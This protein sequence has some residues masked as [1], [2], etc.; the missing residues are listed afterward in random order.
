MNSSRLRALS[1]I[2]AASFFSASFDSTAQ[3]SRAAESS[4]VVVKAGSAGDDAYL[5]NWSKGLA[6]AEIRNWA[7]GAGVRLNRQRGPVENDCA[8][9]V[10]RYGSRVRFQG[11]DRNRIYRV[12][13]D[14]VGFSNP[15]GTD[16]QARL[17]ISAGGMVLRSLSF[18]DLGGE[19]SLCLIE[20]PYSMTQ[21]GELELFFREYSSTGGYFGVWSIVLAD[22]PDIPSKILG[23]AEGE[24]VSEGMEPRTGPLELKPSLKK[25][26]PGERQESRKAPGMKRE[27]SNA[28]ERVK[29]K[30]GV[31]E[32]A[33]EKGEGTKPSVKA[34]KTRWKKAVPEKKKPGPEKKGKEQ[35]AADG[36][37][38]Q[39]VKKNEP[40]TDKPREK[41]SR[42]GEGEK[43]APKIEL[44]RE[45]DGSTRLRQPDDPLVPE[46][47]GPD[48]KKNAPP[49]LPRV[50]DKARPYPDTNP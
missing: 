23:P 31:L 1:C 9:F 50:E 5:L 19:G 2:I 32:K 26:R 47:K 39:S 49:R 40:A 43:P 8:R 20:V 18:G 17:E 10:G 4:Y 29:I 48:E 46:I 21:G 36:E 28:A 3:D 42:D 16:I 25:L 7:R 37:K 15:R 44:P 22:R 14:F 24:R 45:P 41:S 12:L 13:I 33:G 11:L 35:S 6:A 27:D 30:K 38:K 34:G